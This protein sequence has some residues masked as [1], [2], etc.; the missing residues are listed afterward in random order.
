MARRLPTVAIEHPF[1]RMLLDLRR[2]SA[3]HAKWDAGT[4]VWR[5]PAREAAAFIEMVD[6]NVK[7]LEKTITILVDWRPI[8]V[9]VPAPADA[10]VPAI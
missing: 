9:G 2:L 7:D 1:D 8:T 4:R 6:R 3:P 5:M 10:P